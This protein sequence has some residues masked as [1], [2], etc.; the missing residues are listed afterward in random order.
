VTVG[1]L[2]N[3]S[4]IPG[5]GASQGGKG[6]IY[7][8]PG[9][10]LRG[11]PNQ[12][13][14]IESMSQFVQLFGGPFGP[15]FLYNDL[16]MFFGEF[17]GGS[18]YVARVV[19]A[20]SV[21]GSVALNDQS[22]GSGI[23]TLEL[24][25]GCPNIDPTTGN[26]LGNVPDPGA[27]SSAITVQPVA[28]ALAGQW[29]LY[30]FYNGVQVEDWG[31][32]VDVPTGVAKINSASSYLYAANLFSTTSGVPGNPQP[33]TAPVALTAG[34]DERGTITSATMAAQLSVFL[35]QLGP[36]IVAIPGYD[37]SIV[38]AALIAH[39]A[40]NGRV[41][42]LSPTQGMSNTS[43]ESAAAAFRGTAG[44]QCAG[45]AWPWVTCPS[46]FGPVVCPPD[47][48]VA[49]LRGRTVAEIGPWQAPAGA[50]GV[51]RFVTGLDPASGVITDAVGN[52]LNDEH[53]NVIRPKAGIRLYGWRSLST[54]TVNYELLS[55]QDTLNLI[56]Y[57]LNVQLQQYAFAVIDSLG[58]L[59][60]NMAQTAKSILE[61]LITAG[62]L[63]PGP[64]STNGQVSD[65]GYLIDTGSD[66]NTSATLAANQAAMNVFVRLSPTAELIPVGV[67]KV[68]VGTAF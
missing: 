43:V 42:N 33:L 46:P 39:G 64:D 28:S 4:T 1:V 36:G 48:F 61:P 9:Q 31:P 25:A 32:F 53:V 2:V 22:T 26:S 23:P 65:P 21:A 41:V 16:S 5:P 11:N 62:A 29:K 63:Y 50:W 66:V 54:D 59:F 47:G 18:A 7:F 12:A 20:G 44:S 3:V 38:G 35:P 30:V 52:A 49:G 6:D 8:V 13:V 24:Q 37:A 67:V 45:Y 51:A 60:S 14:L 34:N 55:E 57:L 58:Q 10:T 68:A 56:S 40:A 15:G 19:G 27:W 17:P